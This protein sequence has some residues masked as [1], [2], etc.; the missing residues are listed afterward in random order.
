M[1]ITVE[2]IIAGELDLLAYTVVYTESPFP[3]VRGQ[4][5]TPASTFVIEC[6]PLC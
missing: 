6:S 1:H 4:R 5:R 2:D 3:P